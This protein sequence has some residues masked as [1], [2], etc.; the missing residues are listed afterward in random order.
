MA[1]ARFHFFNTRRKR[2]AGRATGP[3]AGRSQAAQPRARY[4]SVVSG[5]GRK[6]GMF[7]G[8]ALEM[9]AL[10]EATLRVRHRG[11][12]PPRTHMAEAAPEELA[13]ELIAFLAGS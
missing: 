10:P 1:A 13:R 6:G 3:C 12:G 7:E 2:G 11:A 4:P 8:F 5:A 9:I